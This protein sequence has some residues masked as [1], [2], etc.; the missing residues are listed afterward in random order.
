[1]NI[2]YIHLHSLTMKNHTFQEFLF[3]YL[4]KKRLS[5][6]WFSQFKLG[7]AGVLSR[8][9]LDTELFFHVFYVGFFAGVEFDGDQ[10]LEEQDRKSTRLNSSH[11]S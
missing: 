6:L 8:S 7:C 3:V 10:C 1:M 11:W 4:A 9:E 5:A 2:S